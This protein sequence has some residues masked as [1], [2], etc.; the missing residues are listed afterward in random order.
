MN[1]YE[2]TE[3]ISRS[4]K[5]KTDICLHCKTVD[6]TAHFLFS[7]A[8]YQKNRKNIKKLKKQEVD[9]SLVSLLNS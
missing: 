3:V 5:I 9:E 6:T 2:V 1:D 8:L 4:G 7:C